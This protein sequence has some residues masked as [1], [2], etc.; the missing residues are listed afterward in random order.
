[1]QGLLSPEETEKIRRK[2][3]EQKAQT[4]QARVEGQQDKRLMAQRRREE[5][6]KHLSIQNLIQ[7]LGPTGN[8]TPNGAAAL[9]IRLLGS[10]MPKK[11]IPSQRTLRRLFVEKAKLLATQ[12]P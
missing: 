11:D 1:M 2:F 4:S 8:L 12:R 5:I 7:R 9:A 3:D 10:V 6:A